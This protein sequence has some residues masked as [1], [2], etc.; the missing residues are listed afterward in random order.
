M[1]SWTTWPKSSRTASRTHSRA[2][3][4]SSVVCENGETFF[5]RS[6]REREWRAVD[7]SRGVKKHVR[8]SARAS[9]KGRVFQ[10]SGKD[11]RDRS[12]STLRP[13]RPVATA[14]ASSRPRTLAPRPSLMEALRDED[15]IISAE[16]EIEMLRD[17]SREPPI[18][19]F[20]RKVRRVFFQAFEER[21]SSAAR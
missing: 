10:K 15:A 5:F 8:V 9:Q 19:A 2:L 4:S 11:T 3:R 20:R 18:A 17:S 14:T 16:G 7:R 13:S 6:V 21:G 1:R 12:T